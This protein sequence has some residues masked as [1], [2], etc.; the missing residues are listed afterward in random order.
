MS[1]TEGYFSAYRN[2]VCSILI[3]H[4]HY[5][6]PAA[7]LFLLAL[8]NMLS[9]FNNLRWLMKQLLLQGKGVIADEQ[10][11]ETELFG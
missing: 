7:H 2:Q 8:A 1:A 4:I 10:A 11:H 6:I 5:C 9:M 3:H